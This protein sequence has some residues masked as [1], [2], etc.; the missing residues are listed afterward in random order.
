MTEK[1]QKQYGVKLDSDYPKAI[2]CPKY[3]NLELAK[4]QKAEYKA[5]KAEN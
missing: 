1:E 5:M 3:T 4:K 2:D